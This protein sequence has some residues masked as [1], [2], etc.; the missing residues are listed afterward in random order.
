MAVHWGVYGLWRQRSLVV[1]VRKSRGPYTGL[2]DLP[3]GAPEDDETPEQTL[4]RELTEECGVVLDHHGA[5]CP[6]DLHVTRDSRGERIDFHHRGLVAAVSVIGDVT[7]VRDVEDVRSVEL[8]DPATAARASLSPLL[9]HA[10][11]MVEELP[12]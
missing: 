10:L 12:P 8:F 2:L 6:V 7:A 11:A 9:L 5:W 4:R 1:A 3:G